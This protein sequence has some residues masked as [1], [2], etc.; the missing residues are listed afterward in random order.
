M[1]ETTT[2]LLMILSLAFQAGC[3]SA[4]GPPRALAPR[5]RA[6]VRAINEAAFV[7]IRT[8][9][10]RQ[11]RLEKPD[12]DPPFVRGTWRELRPAREKAL[13]F[14]SIADIEV[15]KFDAVK[16]ALWTVGYLGL[17]VWALATGVES[18]HR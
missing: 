8:P 17:G 15:F 6:Q 11:Y 14:D 16:T 12:V 1:K 10:G 4:I 9:D 3:H 5:D 7:K 2:S 13:P 18:I